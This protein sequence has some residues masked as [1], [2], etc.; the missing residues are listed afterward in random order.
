MKITD[1]KLPQYIC[2]IG[3]ISLEI[4]TEG[5]NQEWRLC[6]FA[7]PSC[8]KKAPQIQRMLLSATFYT[9]ISNLAD[10]CEKAHVERKLPNDNIGGS[11]RAC[12]LQLWPVFICT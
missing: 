8:P 5:N 7:D 2:E 11:K 10:R 1:R 3:L 6:C 4:S 9:G 12:I